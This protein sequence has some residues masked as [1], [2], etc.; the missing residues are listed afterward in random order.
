MGTSWHSSI[1]TVMGKTPLNPLGLQEVLIEEFLVSKL[2][3]FRS[4]VTPF[5]LAGARTPLQLL[6]NSLQFSTFFLSTY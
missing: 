3:I 2:L 5:H 6:Q 1:Q 4:E